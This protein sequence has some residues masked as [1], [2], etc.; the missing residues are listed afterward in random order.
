MTSLST[1]TTPSI[2]ILHN[3]GMILGSNKANKAKDES[4]SM[5]NQIHEAWDEEMYCE[6]EL[7]LYGK[8]HF[9]LCISCIDDDVGQFLHIILSPSL[10]SPSGTLE[11]HFC[12][13]YEVSCLAKSV[14]ASLAMRRTFPLLTIP[15]IDHQKHM[16]LG[17]RWW[18]VMALRQ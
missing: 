7:F 14:I 12:D 5:L 6:L 11:D 1:H 17:W 8:N 9:I 15:R 3:F 10:Q 2:P 13:L 18:V 16:I 4:M